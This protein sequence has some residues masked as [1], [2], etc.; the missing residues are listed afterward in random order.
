[1]GKL[2]M[3]PGCLVRW[4]QVYIV[5][6]PETHD[7]YLDWAAEKQASLGGF[8]ATN[9]I[10][11]GVSR[12]PSQPFLDLAHALEHVPNIG[13][14]W[15]VVASLN[16]FW[17]PQLPLQQLVERTI[18]RG[19]AR[20]QLVAEM[21]ALTHR[22]SLQ[23]QYEVQLDEQGSSTATG[24][25]LNPRVAGIELQPQ[26]A[27]D[28]LHTCILTPLTLL[29][30]SSLEGLQQ[31]AGAQGHGSPYPPGTL[32]LGAV[33]KAL[34]LGQDEQH[35]E[36][37][38]GPAARA[39]T[40]VTLR[41]QACGVIPQTDADVEQLLAQAS[42]LK[43]WLLRFDVIVDDMLA[44]KAAAHQAKSSTSLPLD[45]PFLGNKLPEGVP[46]RFHT[47]S[48]HR[49]QSKVQHPFYS[50]TAHDIGR[51]APTPLELP[52]VYA[53]G[54]MHFTSTFFLGPYRNNALN[55]H[56]TT[57]RVHKKLDDF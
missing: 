33:V 44:A 22:L 47:L 17:G 13:A 5:T 21:Q 42:P 53:G 36:A 46:Q 19:K 55:T 23:G 26:G 57:S 38:Q 10:C 51:R 14:G 16:V 24:A 6:S 27:S 15:V 28:G 4:L 31:A 48:T 30:K 50:T 41:G 35:K 54:S 52:D 43:R 40:E 7:H 9:L 20:N 34:L 49:N 37:K 1:M 18:V 3:V 45:M 12:Q 25:C 8:P 11:T 56:Y 39:L 32:Q 2:G 29:H